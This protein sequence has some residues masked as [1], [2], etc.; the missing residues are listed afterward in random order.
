MTKLSKI[1]VANYIKK[2]NNHSG[3]SSEKDF[4]GAARHRTIV[5]GENAKAFGSQNPIRPNRRKS[6]VLD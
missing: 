3:T 5:Y 6:N 2:D 1:K 4:N